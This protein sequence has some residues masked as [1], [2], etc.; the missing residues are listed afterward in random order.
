M[1]LAQSEKC[2]GAGGGAPVTA[3]G[4]LQLRQIRQNRMSH[5]QSSIVNRLLVSPLFHRPQPGDA[6][7]GWRVGAEE[8]AEAAAR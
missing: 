5:N 3:V 2:R 8:L 6:L 4:D 1:L 7:F